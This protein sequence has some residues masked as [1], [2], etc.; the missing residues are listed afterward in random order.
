MRSSGVS[1]RF[2]DEPGASILS[3][4]GRR[5]QVCTYGCVGPGAL[6]LPERAAATC[7]GY[8][9]E[10]VRSLTGRRPYLRPS[11]RRGPCAFLVQ[12]AQAAQGAPGQEITSRK[13][14]SAAGAKRELE[15]VIPCSSTTVCGSPQIWRQP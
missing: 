3:E 7:I 2:V 12:H 11:T 8:T 5:P 4:F 6:F 10:S 13:H 15:Q 9:R 14:R 1:C